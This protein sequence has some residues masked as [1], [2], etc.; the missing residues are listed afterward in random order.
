VEIERRTDASSISRA[1]PAFSIHIVGDALVCMAHNIADGRQGRH[2]MG[3]RRQNFPDAVIGHKNTML[4][5]GNTTA[6]GFENAVI[7]PIT[8]YFFI[9]I[10]LW[11]RWI[12]ALLQLLYNFDKGSPV[13][14]EH[15]ARR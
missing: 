3:S 12:D 13:T 14:R 11:P 5:R 15:K 2:Q 7:L 4:Y 8:L 1:R 10:Y 9:Y 6:Y